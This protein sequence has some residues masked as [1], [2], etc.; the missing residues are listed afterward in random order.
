MLIVPPQVDA[1]SQVV[2]AGQSSRVFVVKKVLKLNVYPEPPLTYEITV[3][4]VTDFAVSNVEQSPV[5]LTLK[6]DCFVSDPM[7]HVKHIS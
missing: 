6:I 3:G 4:L 2:I 1:T 7:V 5:C